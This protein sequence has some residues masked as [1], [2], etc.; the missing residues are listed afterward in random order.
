MYLGVGN[1]YVTR[2]RYDGRPELRIQCLIR[3]PGW[4]KNQGLDPGS[5][6]NIPDYISESLESILGLKI[7]KF[8]GADQD[9]GSGIRNLFDPRSGILRYDG[10]LLTRRER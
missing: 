3:D 8:F 5:V 10:Q 9:L 6:M 4:V 7:L 1:K 2:L